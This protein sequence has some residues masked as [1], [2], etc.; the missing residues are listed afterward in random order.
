MHHITVDGVVDTAS[1]DDKRPQATIRLGDVNY[2]KTRRCE[3]G[4]MHHIRVENVKASGPIAVWLQGPI[5]DSSLPH[6]EAL[7]GGRNYGLTAPHERV[8]MD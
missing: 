3:M 8:T 2:H 6:L 1:G 4:E 7:P 5:C